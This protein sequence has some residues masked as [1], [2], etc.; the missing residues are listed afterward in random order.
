MMLPALHP[1][2]RSTGMHCSSKNSKRETAA[3][4]L[5]PPLDNTRDIL[6]LAG[7]ELFRS[8]VTIAEPHSPESLLLDMGLRFV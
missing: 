2:M 8:E 7:D 1:T 6:G 3:I 5:S 4:G